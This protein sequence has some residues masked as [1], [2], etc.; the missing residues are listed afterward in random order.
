MKNIPKQ[1]ETDCAHLEFYENF[2]VASIKDNVV[3]DEAHLNCLINLGIEQY[4]GEKFA[5]ISHRKNS[6]NVNPMIYL[7]LKDIEGLSGIAV[8]SERVAALNNAHFEKHFSPIPYQLFLNLET[9]KKWV[10]DII[11]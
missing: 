1:I 8:V 11:Y 3:F 5:Y 7:R 2:V 6:Y 10:N 4:K 9:A